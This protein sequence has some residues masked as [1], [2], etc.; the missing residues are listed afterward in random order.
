MQ[1]VLKTCALGILAASFN[2]AWAAGPKITEVFGASAVILS[3]SAQVF[4]GLA[5]GASD[6]ACASKTG[7]SVCNSCSAVT[8]LTACNESRIY[9]SLIVA[10]NVEDVANEAFDLVAEVDGSSNV[11]MIPETGSSDQQIRF[12]WSNICNQMS[13]ISGGCETVTGSGAATVT[14]NIAYDRDNDNQFSTGDGDSTQITFRVFKPSA[15]QNE[16]SSGHSGIKDFRPYPGDE[17]VYIEGQDGPDIQADGSFPNLDYSG[18]EAQRVRVFAATDGIEHARY[19]SAKELTPLQ[20]L[21]V[22]EEGTALSSKIY[23]GLE[24]DTLYFFRLALVDQ[25]NNVV[26]YIPSAADATAEHCDST[27]GAKANC[28]WAA[29]PSQVLG[30]LTKDLNCFVATAAY[31]SSMQPEL[32][33][34]RAFRNN[35]LLPRQWGRGFVKSYYTY[36]PYAARYIHD[37]PVLRAMARAAIWPAV[38]FSKLTFKIGLVKATAVSIALILL[39]AAALATLMTGI[40]R[41]A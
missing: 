28:K 37:K 15:T 20:D 13:G 4:G 18:A 10:I 11:E 27:D 39:M 16:F 19:N 17:K 1:R 9:D 23:D 33:T 38:G 7:S 2:F 29:T 35:V 25:A 30:L 36:G 41:R 5:G 3:G 21:D 8:G 40:K 26:E 22:E 6:G 12:K 34:L 14:I 24:N 31:G 32:K